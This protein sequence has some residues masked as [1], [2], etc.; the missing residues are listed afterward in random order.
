MR[1]YYLSLG[2]NIEP[3]RNLA[4]AVQLLGEYGKFIAASTVFITAPFGTG[5]PQPD[6][7]NA[8]VIVESG[9]APADFKNEVIRPIEAR[10]G[11]IR[12]RDRYASRTID[13]DIL[14]V[15]KEIL[16]VGR[17]RIPS[18]EILE[19]SYVAIPL[20]EVAPDVV[21]PVEGRT[22]AEIAAGFEE[23]LQIHPLDLT[24]R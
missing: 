17:R 18:P 23:E 20:A 6:Y 4:A 8:V 2:S 5:E 9:L 3:E 14:M 15:D 10:L 21:H 1:R 11:R 22:L 7:L 16:R 24:E 12:S 13:I 19:R